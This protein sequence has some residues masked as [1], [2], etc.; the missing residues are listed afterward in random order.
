MSAHDGVPETEAELQSWF[1]EMDETEREDFLTHSVF[2][3]IVYMEHERR[4]FHNQDGFY[5]HLAYD[6]ECRALGHEP[7]FVDGEEEPYDD[8]ELSNDGTHVSSWSGDTLCGETRWGT[9]CTE[10]EGE[11]DYAY[12]IPKLWA[13]PGVMTAKEAP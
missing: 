10:C 13:L 8:D 1:E 4:T 2:R 6:K 12:S 5:A 3:D 7:S 11:C 9:A